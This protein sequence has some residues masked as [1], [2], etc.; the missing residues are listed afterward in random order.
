MQKRYFWAQRTERSSYLQTE[1]VF[2]H[3]F[4]S[5]GERAAWLTDG[6]WVDPL[7]ATDPE[8]RRIQRRITAGEEVTFPVEVTP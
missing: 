2:I 3:R 1:T 5:A 4:R 6:E 8:V 7:P